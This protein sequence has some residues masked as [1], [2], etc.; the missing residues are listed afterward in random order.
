MAE[1]ITIARPYAVAAFRLAKESSTQA[2]WSNMLAF[3]ASVSADG[4]MQAYIT[5]PNVTSS[6]LLQSFLAI[7]AGRLNAQGESLIK[8]L[9]EYGRLSIL[10]EIASAFEVLKA[11]DGGVLQAEITTAS[12]LT[13]IEAAVLVQKLEAKFSKKIEVNVKVD[14]ELIGGIKILVGDTVIDASVKGQLQQMAY[15]LKS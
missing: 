3:T 10:P 6:D 8:L 11:E 7:C 14:P 5:D 1:T 12:A 4:K 2:V 9:V 15:S 13:D